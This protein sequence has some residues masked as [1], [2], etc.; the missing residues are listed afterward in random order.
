MLETHYIAISSALISGF[1][2][3]ILTAIL[4]LGYGVGRVL[5]ARGYATGDPAKRYQGEFNIL[6]LFGIVFLNI[7]QALSLLGFPVGI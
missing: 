6:C 2:F 3:P 1:H 4:L 7:V 5:Y